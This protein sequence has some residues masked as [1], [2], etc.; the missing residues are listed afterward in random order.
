MTEPKKPIPQQIQE[1]VDQ[2]NN[3]DFTESCEAV[4]LARDRET[5]IITI[6]RMGD[7]TNLLTE[8]AA[9]KRSTEKVH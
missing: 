2:M 5:N 3:G 9:L 8:A 4:L 6:V 7:E 1:I